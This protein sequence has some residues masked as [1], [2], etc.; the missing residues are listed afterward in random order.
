M[1]ALAVLCVR[2]EAAFLLEWLAHHRVVGFSDVLV[3][4]N[5]CSDGTDTMLDRL[6]QMGWLTHIRNTRVHNGS[7]QWAAMK[8]ADK[9]PMVAQADWILPL[10]ID[11][12]VNIHAGDRTLGA[13]WEALPQATAIP[14]TWRLFGNA[15]VVEYSDVPVTQ[16]FTRAAP[17]PCSWPWKSAM[18][19]TLYRND[20]TYGKLGIHRPRQP[21]RTRLERS[22]WMDGSG[23][24]LPAE[25]KT[26]KIFS[27]FHMDNCKLVQLNHYPLGAMHSYVLKRARGRAV[28]GDHV[29]G[30][31]YW[32]ERNFNQVEDKSVHALWPRVRAVLDE[33]LSDKKLAGL[34][35][36][37]VAWRQDRFAEL[38]LKDDARALMGQL[39]MAPQSRM[40][41][42]AEAQ[43]LMAHGMRAAQMKEAG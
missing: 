2:D 6:A 33:L 24:V 41:S 1:R 35:A 15:G 39:M 27:N 42:M 40:L 5:D 12:F 14:L 37:A 26:K 38:M 19:K 32:V 11:E 9:H 18:F 8:Q 23:R 16:L 3:F 17:I 13:L 34:H 30:M 21:D 20:G 29:L 10:D 4:S 22:V 28:H 36:R 43:G 7:P 25:F 31:G